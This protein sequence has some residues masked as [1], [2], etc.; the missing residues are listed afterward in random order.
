MRI[1]SRV[2]GSIGQEQHTL[3]EDSERLYGAGSVRS[4]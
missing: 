4:V 2:A 1:I 3:R